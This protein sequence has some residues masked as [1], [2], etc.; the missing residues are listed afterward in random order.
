MPRPRLHD[1]DLRNRLL[2]RAGRIVAENGVAAL[3]L[4]GLAGE[5]NTS[6]TA[7][8]SLF[9]GKP[10]LLS[11]LFEASFAGFGAAQ[12]AVPVTGDTFTDLAALGWCYREWAHLHPHLY[13]VMFG[14]VLAGFDPEPEQAATAEATIEPLAA[15]VRR[16]VDRGVL[17]GDPFTI[18]FSIWATV[19]GLV[20]LGLVGC[21]PPEE[22][23]RP[24][25]EAS[26][27][28]LV[29]GWCAG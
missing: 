21:A 26:T 20:S 5:E 4:R 7:V 27:I 23:A 10:A 24:I 25:F 6:T 28:A 16:G 15:V 18:T 14:G 12:T 11:A 29:R 2:E 9:G 3:S 13:G 22:L 17:R 19:H 1:E 8:Y